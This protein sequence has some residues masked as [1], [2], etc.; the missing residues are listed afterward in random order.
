MTDEEQKDWGAELTAL[1]LAVR[2]IADLTEPARERVMR[3]LAQRFPPPPKKDAPP[4]LQKV[5]RGLQ[6]QG[7]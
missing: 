2:A 1:D 6:G 4:G 7:T 3:Y 5:M